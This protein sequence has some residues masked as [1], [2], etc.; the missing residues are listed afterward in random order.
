MLNVVTDCTAT[1]TLTTA[2]VNTLNEFCGT[3]R[4]SAEVLMMQAVEIYMIVG[5]TLMTTSL[6]TLQ[7]CLRYCNDSPEYS[8]IPSDCDCQNRLPTSNSHITK[9]KEDSGIYYEPVNQNYSSQD[10]IL[11]FLNHKILITNTSQSSA[12]QD[13]H[14]EN[15]SRTTNKYKRTDGKYPKS[16][17]DSNEQLLH[18]YL[19]LDLDTTKNNNR[20]QIE[21][22]KKMIENF[23]AVEKDLSECINLHIYIFSKYVDTNMK[24]NTNWGQNAKNDNLSNSL[25]L[26]EIQSKCEQ[27]VSIIKQSI[28]QIQQG[29]SQ[30]EPAG[31]YLQK[32]EEILN[33]VESTTKYT[34]GS[35]NSVDGKSETTTLTTHSTDDVPAET[36]HDYDITPTTSFYDN[37]TLFDD[38]QNFRST[39]MP[40][41]TLLTEEDMKIPR[42]L[43][44]ELSNGSVTSV[45]DGYEEIPNSD[46]ITDVVTSTVSYNAVSVSNSDEIVEPDLAEINGSLYFSFGDEHIPARF[47]QHLNGSLNVALD[48]FSMCNHVL[49]VN[50]SHFM[51]LLCKCISLQ[52][53]T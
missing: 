45:V 7:N 35:N 5:A 31:E 40:E 29:F 36:I 18:L 25:V 13:R 53:C 30:E 47:I 37:S 16:K 11:R 27:P 52:N 8:S 51:N 50:T 32:E 20:S 28:Y 6:G 19:D 21:E 39:T 33:R 42:I 3:S 9:S 46:F 34:T 10:L 26:T 14:D 44:K 49:K 23:Q 15:H 41:R 43:T 1:G 4:T 12:V 22:L 38:N 2:V 17:E 24:T 48:G